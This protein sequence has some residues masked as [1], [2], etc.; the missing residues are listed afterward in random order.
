MSIMTKRLEV[1]IY[2][3]IYS[4]VTWGI[5]VGYAQAQV[6]VAQGKPQVAKK[7]PTPLCLTPATQE[8][9]ADLIKENT[10]LHSWVDGVKACV[11][12]AHAKGVTAGTCFGEVNL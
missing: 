7:T 4:V 11:L 2:L 5:V 3:L 8:A 10:E 12:E 9:I 6:G 1:L